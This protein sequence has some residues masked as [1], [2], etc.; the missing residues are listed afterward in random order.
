MLISSD[1]ESVDTIVWFPDDYAAPS[2]EVCQWFDDWLAERPGRTFVYV[3]RTFDAAPA[4]WRAM[5]PLVPA[6]KKP[7]IASA[8]AND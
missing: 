1:M 7:N 5:A 3:G 4:Y 2:P 8:T 6:D